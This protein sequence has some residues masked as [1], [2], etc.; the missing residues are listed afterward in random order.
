M[1]YP[2]FLKP[3][4][5]L[6][7]IAPSYGCVIEPY[8]TCFEKAIVRFHRMG[9]RTKTGPNCFLGEGV[10]KSNSPEKCGAEV[11]AFFKD[12]FGTDLTDDQVSY[13]LNGFNSQ[14]GSLY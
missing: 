4:G 9:F 6:G 1:R 10:G 12:Y 11:N 13:M 8:H 3:G 14:G 5:T 7:F 2:D